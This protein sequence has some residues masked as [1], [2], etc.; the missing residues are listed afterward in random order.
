MTLAL[1]DVKLYKPRKQNK[2]NVRKWVDALRSGEYAQTRNAL[3]IRARNGETHHCCLGVACAVAGIEAEPATYPWGSP[4][5]AFKF[6][7]SD[8][9]LP[10]S[11]QRWL[12]IGKG[13]PTVRVVTDKGAAD[14][15]LAGLND[16]EQWTFD[17]IADLIERDWL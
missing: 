6:D 14:R 3:A 8:A 15:S 17:Q 4:S 10:G 7:G 11:A 13:N 1:D 5:N 16:S 12:G 9:V 2:E